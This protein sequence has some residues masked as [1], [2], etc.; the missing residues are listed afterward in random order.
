ME[1]RRDKLAL[2]TLFGRGLAYPL[3]ALVLVSSL[4]LHQLDLAVHRAF[5]AVDEV[6]VVLGGPRFE[7]ADPLDDLVAD[8]RARTR[9]GESIVVLPWYPIV[10]FLAERANPTKFDWLF[11]GYLPSDA[12]VAGFLDEIDRFLRRRF[13]AT[14]RYGRFLV[15]TRKDAP[16]EQP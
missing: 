1:R 3:V 15:L 8:A 4:T 11:S 10:Y 5:D 16:S 9:P 14:R 12:A 2:L 7:R 6:E 13:Q